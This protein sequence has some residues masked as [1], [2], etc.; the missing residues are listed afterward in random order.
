MPRVATTSTSRSHKLAEGGKTPPNPPLRLRC[1]QDDCPWSFRTQTDLKRHLPR[2]MSHEEREKQ[3]DL[4]IAARVSSLT[5]F[6]RMYKCPQPGCSHKSL[7]KSN[8][9]THYVSKHTGIKPHVCKQCTYCASDPSCLHRH[10]RA[11]H[12]YVSGTA[13]RKKRSDEYSAT[14]PAV[15][16]PT[17]AGSSAADYSEFI[18]DSWTGASSPSSST[19]SPFSPAPGTFSDEEFASDNEILYPNF[20]SSSSSSTDF[21]LPASPTGSSE[22]MWEEAF[23]APLFPPCEKSSVANIVLETRPTAAPV[24]QY[25]AEGI[26]FFAGGLDTT[27]L[28]GDVQQQQPCDESLLFTLPSLYDPASYALDAFSSC[29]FQEGMCIPTAFVGE[30]NGALC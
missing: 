7:Q 3:Y 28:T 23:E 17:T 15:A 5:I 16:E 22:W 19:Y 11:V 30:W 20:P 29:G 1:P 18:A 14:V 13:P 24:I 26:D 10:M 8:L 21:F 6:L 12:A 4:F 9:E 27:V 25:P 2:H